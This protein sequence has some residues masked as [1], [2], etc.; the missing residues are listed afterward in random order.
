MSNVRVWVAIAAVSMAAPLLAQ[1]GEFP[2]EVVVRDISVVDLAEGQVLPAR[3]IVVRGTRVERLTPTGG[4][5]PR[6][7]R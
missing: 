2:A 7:Q 3:D 6:G 5:L 1:T 4:A